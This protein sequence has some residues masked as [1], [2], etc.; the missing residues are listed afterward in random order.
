MA[1]LDIKNLTLEI[2]TDNGWIKALDKANLSVREGEIQALVGESGSGKSLIVRAISGGLPPQM[3]LTADRMTWRGANL[4]AMN[5]EQR[6]E[7]MR[8]D[9]AVVYQDPLASLDPSVTLGEQLEESVPYEFVGKGWFWEKQK[10]RKRIAI[11]LVHKVGIKDHAGVMSAYP[12]QI[13]SDIGQKFMIAMAL[14]SQPALLIA[15]DPTRGME[16]TTKVQILKLFKR[17]NQTKR[18]SILFVGHD[19][20]AISSMSDSMTVLYCGQ[21]VES[22]PIKQLQKR[23]LHPYTKALLDSA[24]SFRADLPPKSPLVT[25]PGTIPTLQHLPIGCRLGPRC[26][27][28]QKTCV[29]TPAV[30]KIHDHFYSCHYPLHTNNS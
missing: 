23:P 28:A 14:V 22:G 20:L 24:P 15:D 18:L 9:I 1:L 26:H 16:A 8:R 5:A 12:H 21:T 29:Q 19:L 11:E 17:L 13:A 25:L 3:R 10:E 27:R 30:R 4:L 7:I 2:D 6:R